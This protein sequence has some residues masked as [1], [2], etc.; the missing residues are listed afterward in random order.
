MMM[1]IGYHTQFDLIMLVYLMGINCRLNH[2]SLLCANI[3]KEIIG[4]GKYW[5]CQFHATCELIMLAFENIFWWKGDHCI[6]NDNMHEFVCLSEIL[7][8]VT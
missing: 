7:L 8:S 1:V 5:K 3:M 6:Q 2:T 4:N